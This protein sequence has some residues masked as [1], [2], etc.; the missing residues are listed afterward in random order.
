GGPDR[1][2]RSIEEPETADP[3]A[4]S[5]PH[6]PRSRRWSHRRA[7]LARAVGGRYRRTRTTLTK[8]P[9]LTSSR[10]SAVHSRAERLGGD[11]LGLDPEH[12]PPSGLDLLRRDDPLRQPEEDAVMAELRRPEALIESGEDGIAILAIMRQDLEPLAR[13]QLDQGRDEQA[14]EELLTAAPSPDVLP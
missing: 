5:V 1:G 6:P 7:V 13:P 12:L 2:A 3:L 11:R 8:D 14:V 4:V 9:W 10:P